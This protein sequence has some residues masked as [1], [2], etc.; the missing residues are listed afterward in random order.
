MKG[1]RINTRS[2]P[3]LV[4]RQ[5]GRVLHKSV[6][7]Q[8]Q[9]KYGVFTSLTLLVGHVSP[10]VVDQ[11][12]GSRARGGSQNHLIQKSGPLRNLHGVEVRLQGLLHTGFVVVV[13][14]VHDSLYNVKRKR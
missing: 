14:L 8:W 6:P 12:A 10:P 2:G 13:D 9:I 11:E 1:Q 5:A 7:H 3:D 4:P